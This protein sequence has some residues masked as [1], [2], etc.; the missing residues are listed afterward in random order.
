MSRAAA[1]ARVTGATHVQIE[2]LRVTVLE[3]E[4]T[5]QLVWARAWNDTFTTLFNEFASP[6][7]G[8]ALRA[9]A[10]AADAALARAGT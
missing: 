8:P 1:K 3:V 6:A 10:D 4:G 5:V 2:D 7:T 9:L